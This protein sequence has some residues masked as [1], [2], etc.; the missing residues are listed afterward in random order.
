M[1][2]LQLSGITAS[3]QDR[4]I[5]HGIDLT[6]PS[7]TT[8]AVL[9]PSGCGKST[10][11][12]VI[13]G[14][15]RPDAGA[16]RLGGE[17]VAGPGQWVSPERRGFGYVAQ[18]GNLFPHL[19]VAA[20]I[21]YG[22][23]RRER[24]ARVRVDELLELVGLSGDYASRRPDQLSGGQQQRVALARALA[25]RPRIVLLDEP[26]SALDPE[27][28]VA[29]RDAVAA[30]LR[31]EQATVVLVT[32]DQA[33][34]LS[35]ADQV[36]IMHDGRFTQVGAPAS[37]YRAP[38]DRRSAASLGEA[39]FLPGELR[40]GVVTCALG[41]LPVPGVTG[42]GACE[43][44]IR[45]EQLRLAD[46]NPEA[47]VAEVTKAAFYGHDALVELRLDDLPGRAMML[48]AR[49][50]GEAAPSV[51]SR[52]SVTVDGQPH[53]IPVAAPVELSEP[54]G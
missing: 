39:C 54:T 34:A 31:H 4:Q 32:H 50:F 28:R 49:T 6:V 14:F 36:A 8:T 19:D 40:G 41:D 33:E 21:V 1:K 9:G 3:R 44:L 52:V 2:T 24:R 27:L 20:N 18:E 12:R 45:P 16:V 47:C 43:V 13:A 48:S 23:P 25:R 11:L 5:L 35:F 30:A 37:V 51:G 38:I 46:P 10:L 29:T 53:V 22:L 17:V 7:G 26:F 42:T 15:L